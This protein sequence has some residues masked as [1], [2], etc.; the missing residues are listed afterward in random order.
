MERG[1]LEQ[2]LETEVERLGYELVELEHLGSKNRPLLRLRIDRPDSAQGKGVTIDDCT[3]VSRAIEQYLEEQGRIAERYVLEVSS[4]G[5]ERPLHRRRDFERFAGRE[6]AI[7]LHRP[8]DIHG[9]RVEGLLLGIEEGVAGESVRLELPSK[10]V[11]EIP[12]NDI[13]RAHLLFRWE[14]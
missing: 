6:V 11:L 14:E 13:A 8:L 2:A 12:R 3:R 1:E 9:K 4:P 7:K 10:E 5:I